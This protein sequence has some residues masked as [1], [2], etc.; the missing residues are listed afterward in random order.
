MVISLRRPSRRLWF[1]LHS[2]RP[3]G[4]EGRISYGGMQANL[5]QPDLI[6]G[7]NLP[8]YVN[9]TVTEEIRPNQPG[10]IYYQGS[11][12]RAICSE[13]TV[14]VPDT[15]VIVQGR[16]GLTLIVSPLKN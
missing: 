16:I 2:Q 11:W 5:V 7:T 3:G 10:R 4:P 1:W 15:P 13:T 6:Q 12:W 9:A 8:C 14:L